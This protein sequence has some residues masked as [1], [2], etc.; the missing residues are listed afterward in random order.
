VDT[1]VAQGPRVVRRSAVGPTDGLLAVG[2]LVVGAWSVA[3]ILELTGHAAALHHHALIEPGAPPL[4][5]GVPLFLVAWLLMVG[6]MMVPAS[7]RAIEVA[8]AG[9][10]TVAGQPRSALSGFLAAYGLVW[11]AFGLVAFVGDMGLHALVHASPWLAARPFL[12]EAAV[13]ALAGAYQLAPIK[14]RGLEA[15]RHP[16]PVS[17]GAAEASGSRRGFRAGLDHGVDCIASSWA[18]M[19]LMFAAGVANLGWMAVLTVA[20]AYEARGRFGRQAALGFGIALL[21]LAL[22]AATGVVIAF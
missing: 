11:T 7:L 8:L 17:A 1:S 10:P 5:V 2:L 18:L 3:A 20:M 13:L 9:A 4:W 22:I 21:W 6:A 19:L 15:C 16:K 14:R 12:I